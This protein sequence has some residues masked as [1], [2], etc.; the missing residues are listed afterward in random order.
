[1]KND[2]SLYYISISMNIILRKPLTKSEAKDLKG[3]QI[4]SSLIIVGNLC[5]LL[6]L[7]CW[8]FNTSNWKFYGHTEKRK[9]MGRVSGQGINGQWGRKIKW[10]IEK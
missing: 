3:L 1:M 6:W 2:A 9:A 8:T 4:L 7:G 5:L 10:E